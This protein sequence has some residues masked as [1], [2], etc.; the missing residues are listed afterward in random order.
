MKRRLRQINANQQ[1]TSTGRKFS[2]QMTHASFLVLVIAPV[3][4]L[5][6]GAPRIESLA[7]FLR[8]S[9]IQR[10]AIATAPQFPELRRL[11]L[12]GSHR[13]LF[14]PNHLMH[15]A[16]SRNSSKWIQKRR[17][18]FIVCILV[19][20]TGSNRIRRILQSS[21]VEKLFLLI[22]RRHLATTWQVGGWTVH[23]PLDVDSRVKKAFGWRELKSIFCLLKNF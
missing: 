8:A 1:E 18:F 12:I 3:S 17:M 14:L 11:L 19:S 9:V 2:R 23:L 4:F 21:W 22:K 20:S 5:L 16:E 13:N 7:P 10:L 15:R 6:Q